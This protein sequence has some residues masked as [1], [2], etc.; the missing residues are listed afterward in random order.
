MLRL[1][2]RAFA[3]GGGNTARVQLAK[4][5][6]V[7]Q[8][9]V[10]D[11]YR[12]IEQAYEL[13]QAI[14]RDI[15]SID[16]ID[17]TLFLEHIAPLRRVF[18][19]ANLEGPWDPI[20]NTLNNGMSKQSLRFCSDVLSRRV[21]EHLVPQDELDSI[22][23]SVDELV[24]LVDASSFPNDVKVNLLDAIEVLR[25]ALHEY[26]LRGAERLKEGWAESVGKVA[27]T[28][29]RAHDSD[30]V[31]ADTVWSKFKWVWDKFDS[32]VTYALKIRPLLEAGAK[33]L[34]MLTEGKP[35]G[36]PPDGDH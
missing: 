23:K 20:F 16:D 5:F 21:P 29:S 28:F 7:G 2:E 26:D 34:P 36:A 15:S 10:F 32:V 3:Q 22:R 27:V 9:D 30:P 18:V 14:E 35:P 1:C 4:L 13:A 12:A 19:V 25:R 31:A 6:G 24:S 17:T 8:D 11:L 33:I